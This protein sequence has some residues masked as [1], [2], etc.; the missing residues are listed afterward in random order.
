MFCHVFS[1]PFSLCSCCFPRE[2]RQG[3][4]KAILLGDL[5]FLFFK[6]DRTGRLK[7]YLN[8]DSRII[9]SFFFLYSFILPSLLDMG[10]WGLALIISNWSKVFSVCLGSLVK[11]EWSKF[12]MLHQFLFT[13]QDGWLCHFLNLVVLWL[14]PLTQIVV[15][16]SF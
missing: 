4:E 16:N 9:C 11:H 14:F 13:W 7:Y 3:Q 2:G 12:N 5:F 8:Q 10:Q 1:L 15:V 6:F